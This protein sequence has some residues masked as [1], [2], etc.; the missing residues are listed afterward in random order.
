MFLLLGQLVTVFPKLFAVFGQLG[1]FVA[2]ARDAGMAEGAGFVRFLLV[3]ERRF[4]LECEEKEACA[5]HQ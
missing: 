5:G 3:F 2:S 4:G 1:V